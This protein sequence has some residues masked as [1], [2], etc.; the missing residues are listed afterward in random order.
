MSKINSLTI[1]ALGVGFAT[2]NFGLLLIGVGLD[3]A[4]AILFAVG[5]IASVIG[6]AGI[7][8]AGVVALVKS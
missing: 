1:E 6:V 4:G 5:V 2:G 7:F 3:T 8:A